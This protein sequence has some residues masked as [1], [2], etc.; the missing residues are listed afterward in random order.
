MD[1]YGPPLSIDTKNVPV[2]YIWRRAD[3]LMWRRKKKKKKKN[4]IGG[5]GDFRWK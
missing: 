5:G 2:R 4:L 3:G 1:R